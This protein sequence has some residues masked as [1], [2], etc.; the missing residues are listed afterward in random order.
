MKSAVFERQQ[1]KLSTAL[2]TLESALKKFPKFAK[3]YMIQGQIYQSQGNVAAARASFATG[4]KACPKEV[5]LWILASRLEEADNKSIKARALLD[6]ARLVNP[7]SDVLWAEAVG[8]EERSGGAAQAKTVL[9]RGT[10][11]VR[12]V[13]RAC[14][15]PH[16]SSTGLQDCPTSGVLWSMAIWAESRPARKAR[17]ADAL[18]KATD[19]P[20]IICTV[21]RLFWAERKIEKARQWFER[22]VKVNPDLGDVWAWWL[23]F[24][25]QHGT[26]VRVLVCVMTLTYIDVVSVVGVPRGG[27]Q[28]L[29]RC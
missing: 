17:S 12:H 22:A 14:L 8:V 2:E 24:E 21:A 1:G 6:K 11:H 19:D 13:R 3:L 18:R 23:K 20:L 10:F 25:M 16:M 7:G 15:G 29:C 26:A 4:V 9:A 5:T 27:R 28:T